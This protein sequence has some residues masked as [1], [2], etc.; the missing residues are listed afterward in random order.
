MLLADAAEAQGDMERALEFDAKADDLL[1]GNELS[2]KIDQVPFHRR[3]GLVLLAAGEP[4]EAVDALT[5]ALKLYLNFLE[6]PRF[7]FV[8]SPWSRPMLAPVKLLADALVA[9]GDAGKALEAAQ[10][11][12]D[13]TES[14]AILTC[15]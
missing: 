7:T 10:I 3:R 15:Y 4:Y 13:V 12:A 1:R 11:R 9:T 14:E 6:H 8:A 5:P 2:H